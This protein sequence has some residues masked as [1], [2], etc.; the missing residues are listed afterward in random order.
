MDDNN[1][2]TLDTSSSSSSLTIPI[3]EQNEKLLSLNI[4]ITTSDIDEKVITHIEEHENEA[5]EE[6][7]PT[8]NTQEHSSHI[9][10]LANDEQFSSICQSHSPQTTISTI[11]DTIITKIEL[12]NDNQLDVLPIIEDEQMDVDDDDDELDDDEEEEEQENSSNKSLKI[13][14]EQSTNKIP[15]LISSKRDLKPTTRTLRSHAR[16]KISLSTSNQI[17]SNIN[18]NVRR[19]SNRG[20]VI[21]KKLLMTL[22][23]KDKKRKTM[24]ERL[25]KDKDNTTV[26]DDI[27]TSSNSDDQTIENT[28]G[29]N[30]SKNI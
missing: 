14:K 1:N 3:I 29:M 15:S 16:G 13:E 19:V 12:N 30:S 4:P 7:L 22:N 9:T 11:L 24:P 26:N 17:S 27:H 20:R 6:N 2:S 25:K 5:I 28:N 23:E 10:N 18:N 8:T 21:E